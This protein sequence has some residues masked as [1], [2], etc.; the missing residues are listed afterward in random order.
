MNSFTTTVTQQ[1]L[2]AIREA[3]QDGHLHP[4][5]PEVVEA[6]PDDVV[7]ALHTAVHDGAASLQPGSLSGLTHAV[8]DFVQHAHDLLVEGVQAGHEVHDA[9]SDLPD[10]ATDDHAGSHVDDHADVSAAADPYDSHD[11]GQ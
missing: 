7:E 2:D 11:D 4:V 10:D 5:E 6:S 3:E 8:G 9:A 1:A